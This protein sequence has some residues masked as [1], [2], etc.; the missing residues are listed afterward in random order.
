MHL[1]SFSATTVKKA[2]TW[3]GALLQRG[4]VVTS[5][6]VY[7]PLLAGTLRL[8]VF[9]DRLLKGYTVAE[10]G[11][12]AT[13]WLS[14]QGTILGDPLYR[15]FEAMSRN[16]GPS[17]NVFVLWR[18]L[19]ATTGGNRAGMTQAVQQRVGNPAF[20]QLQEMLAWHYAELKD[21]PAAIEAFGQVGR[22]A[23]DARNQVR[24]ELLQATMAFK[25]KD[26]RYG[27]LL[28]QRL[29]DKTPMS[30]FR[31]A[32]QQT[33]EVYMPELRPAPKPQQPGK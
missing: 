13:P 1:H 5:G 11:L 16:A 18:Q 10:A 4:A 8:D 26:E 32:V 19:M 7:E 17:H 2:N 33:A 3:A 9:Y 21:Y 25:S 28:M 23:Q 29:L 27:R 24:A 12:M 6:N 15:P 30:P 20:P 14:W 22:R 31:P